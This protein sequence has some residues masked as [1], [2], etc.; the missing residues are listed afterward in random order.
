MPAHEGSIWHY[1][2]TFRRCD[3]ITA[4][5]LKTPAEAGASGVLSLAVI[6]GVHHLQVMRELEVGGA[7]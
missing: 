4:H 7:G 3:R 5:T 2:I 6:V 1:P